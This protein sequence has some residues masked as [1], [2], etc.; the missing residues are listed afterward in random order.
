MLR[1]SEGEGKWTLAKGKVFNC[2]RTGHSCLLS[3][4]LQKHYEQDKQAWRY[5]KDK[6][7]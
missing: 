6:S 3:G 1:M 7:T 2:S 4:L 5:W